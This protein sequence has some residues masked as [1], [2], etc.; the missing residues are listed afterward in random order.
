MQRTWVN[1]EDFEA[2]RRLAQAQAEVLT[3]P[4]VYE[5]PTSTTAQEAP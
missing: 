3:T 2:L 5:P 4:L 1:P